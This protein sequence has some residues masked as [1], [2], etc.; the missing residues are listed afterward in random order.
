MLGVDSFIVNNILTK[1]GVDYKIFIDFGFIINLQDGSQ[2]PFRLEETGVTING[3]FKLFRNYV[4]AIQ[5][6]TIQYSDMCFYMS[7]IQIASNHVR[8]EK[9]NI[10][11]HCAIIDNTII[12][13]KLI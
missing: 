4:F 8:I 7:N 11:T 10:I 3:N 13:I 5:N 1:D 2:I 6:N 12:T 9:N